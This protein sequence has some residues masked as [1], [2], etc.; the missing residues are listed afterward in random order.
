[1][2]I[3]LLSLSLILSLTFTFYFTYHSRQTV[4]EKA[5]SPTASNEEKEPIKDWE[6]MPLPEGFY[7]SSA[8]F[9]ENGE[10]VL[11]GSDI[12]IS[13]DNGNTWKVITEGRGF[14]RCTKDGGKTFDKDC[15]TQN[16]TKLTINE[17]GNVENAE[18]DNN[19]RLYLTTYYEHHGALWS[20][21][22][23]DLNELWFGLHF[24]SENG[25]ANDIK[26]WTTGSF[27]RLRNKIFVSAASSK[28]DNYNWITTVDRGKTW[29]KAKFNLTSDRFFIDTNNGLQISKGVIKQTIDS[30]KSWKIID[31]PK[32]PYSPV[33]FSYY[34]IDDKTGFAAGDKGLIAATKDGG[35]TWKHFD[36]GTKETFWGV[37]ALDEKNAW[38]VGEKGLIFE[39][40]DGGETWQNIDLGF[41][42]DYYSTL[43]D[44]SIKIDRFHRSVWIIKDG[45]IFRKTVK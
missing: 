10:I 29:H 1:M 41:S 6:E 36:S 44:N 12:R 13:K 8:A 45:K 5:A 21:P 16:P 28:D 22:T 35:M 7:A 20:V 11:I 18:L 24:I 38:A 40:A 14:D 39:T 9:G 37:I 30:G 23:E 32:M 27:I 3:I 34:F 15:R 25:E 43:Y 26:Y 17:I 4:S 31:L 33:Y 19:G 42:K 2:K